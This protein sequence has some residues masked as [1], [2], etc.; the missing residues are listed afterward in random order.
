MANQKIFNNLD[1]QGLS[2]QNAIVN[3]Y[4]NLAAIT[5]ATVLYNFGVNHTAFRGYAKDTKL[6]YK[7][8]GTALEVI[9]EPTERITIV[10][11]TLLSLADVVALGVDLRKNTLYKNDAGMIV[12]VTSDGTATLISDGSE[13]G[14]IVFKPVTFVADTEVVFDING[15]ATIDAQF[16]KASAVTLEKAENKF[17]LTTG[18][19]IHYKDGAE[20]YL[21]S[22]SKV[23]IID[24]ATFGITLSIGAEMVVSLNVDLV[25]SVAK[26]TVTNQVLTSSIE[27]LNATFGANSFDPVTDV[28]TGI[29][30]S[31][32]KAGVV[33]AT[34]NLTLTL[35]NVVGTIVGATILNDGNTITGTVTDLTGGNWQLD[36]LAVDFSKDV[37]LTIV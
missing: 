26:L 25:T 1:L 17:L 33:L 36:F 19:A 14:R 32:I 23:R 10:D 27:V 28:S 31:V 13:S 16:G 21:D 20:H 34:E 15:D 4:D 24:E 29:T 37:V 3:S 22:S 5:A 18:L 11:N 7:W 9:P 12:D 8:T 30:K 2:I 35:N 6:F